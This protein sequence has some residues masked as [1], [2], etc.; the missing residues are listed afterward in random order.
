MREQHQ[1]KGPEKKKKTPKKYRC[2]EA[3]KFTVD[4]VYM[5]SVCHFGT[6]RFARKLDDL[7]CLKIRVER[8]C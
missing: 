8:D 6:A 3:I 5:R 1:V 7:R 2:E 4:L